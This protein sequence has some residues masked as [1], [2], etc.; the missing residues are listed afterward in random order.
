MS[1]QIGAV[2]PAFKTVAVAADGTFQTV[3]LDDFKG[4]Y[5]VLFFYPMDF[6]FVCPTEIIAFSDKA[7][8]FQ[9]LGAQVIAC[10]TD[11]Q[12]SHLAWTQQPRKQGGLG[13][14]AIP[15]L[16]DVTKTIAKDYG[17]LITEGDDAGVALRGTFIIDP[18]Q[19]LRIAHVNDLPIGRNVD[20]YLRLLEALRFHAEHGEVCPA[21]WQKGGKSIKTDPAASK[22][23]FASA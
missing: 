19:K 3:S 23:Y 12:F 2:A 21:N 6:T 10:S 11:T 17:V 7:A 8:E 4:Q 20:E 22:E 9:K 18:E 13:S 14:M 1:P 16:A 5:V 15:I